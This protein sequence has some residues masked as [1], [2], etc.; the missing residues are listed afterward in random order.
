MLRF[1]LLLLCFL[2]FNGGNIKDVSVVFFF[3]VA[4]TEC[5]CFAA[6]GKGRPSHS[7]T[8]GVA[9]D[10]LQCRQ[11]RKYETIYT[12]YRKSEKKLTANSF[13]LNL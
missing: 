6:Q 9:G 3:K 2:V 7:L 8:S 11:C 5:D 1:A 12:N 10:P 4:E 13:S